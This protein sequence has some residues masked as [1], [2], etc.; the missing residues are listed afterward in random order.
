MATK[1]ELVLNNAIKIEFGTNQAAIDYRTAAKT[2]A[3][4]I[5]VTGLYTETIKGIIMNRIDEYHAGEA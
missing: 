2:E 4:G 1:Y 3:N 5:E